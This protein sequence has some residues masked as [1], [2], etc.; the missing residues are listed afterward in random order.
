MAPISLTISISHHIKHSAPSF[1]SPFFAYFPLALSSP[2]NLVNRPSSSS[3]PRAAS[4]LLVPLRNTI[5]TPIAHFPPPVFCYPQQ[6]F[7]SKHQ[8]HAVFILIPF[9]RKARPSP[10]FLLLLHCAS[11]SS[12]SSS[13]VEKFTV[14]I[15]NPLTHASFVVLENEQQCQTACARARARALLP[16]AYLDSIDYEVKRMPRKGGVGLFAR[17]PLPMNARL[18]YHGRS[19]TEKYQH[20]VVCNKTRVDAVTMRYIGYVVW[21]GKK[22]EY[23]DANPRHRGSSNWFG[24][25]VNE[26]FPGERTW[27]WLASERLCAGLCL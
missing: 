25:R 3:T 8:P 14:P 4:V 9:R 15:Q 20:L 12:G 21:S 10:T 11:C 5:V 22:G 1:P 7:T 13:T 19:I 17:R 24:G 16:R 2:H 23:L 26:P 6:P 18:V 27:S